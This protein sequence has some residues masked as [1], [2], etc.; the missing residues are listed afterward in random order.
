MTRRKAWLAVTVGAAVLLA[1]GC[2]TKTNGISSGGGGGSGNATTYS[3][4]WG[5]ATPP[6]N[7]L[8]VQAATFAQQVEQKS[9]GRIKV[10]DV[11]NAALGAPPSLVQQVKSGAI[12]MTS[13]APQYFA[14]YAKSMD[15][16]SLP[17]LFA[18]DKSALDIMRGPAG[19]TVSDQL[20][21]QSGMTVLAWGSLGFTQLM[22]KSTPVSTPADMRGMKVRV[23]PSAIGTQV[24]RTLGATPVSL[25]STEL[26]TALQSG[27]VVGDIDP[28]PQLVSFKDYTVA[29]YMTQ[30]NLFYNPDVVA[31]NT[32]FFQ[33]L[34]GDLRQ[35]VKAAAVAA[36]DK[37]VE[38]NTQATNDGLKT[39]KGSG[40]TV[41]ELT[42]AQRAQFVRAEQP[43]YAS[44][45]ASHGQ[46]L[47]GAFKKS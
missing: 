42:D 40:V 8:T 36:T 7:P 6:G 27:T 3:L 21:Q 13:I 38:V 44:F 25:D 30:L 41:S 24:V 10:R 31:I 19:T 37:E 28:V 1:A 9:G 17:F 39:I 47:L 4:T 23:L 2:G 46:D 32:K 20:R 29:K 14:P 33:S 22:T 16:F 12:Q 43:V 34:P 45:A 15:V 18:D 35:V 26:L 11:E 5:G